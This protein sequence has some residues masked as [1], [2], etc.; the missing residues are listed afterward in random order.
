M[1]NT[2]EAIE[3]EK[4]SA[5][6][7]PASEIT[8]DLVLGIGDAIPTALAFVSPDDGFNLI[9]VN[10]AFTHLMGYAKDDLRSV[11]GW[12]EAAFPDPLFSGQWLSSWISEVEAARTEGYPAPA[13]EGRVRCK[14]GGYRDVVIQTSLLGNLIMLAFTDLTERRRVEH[15]GHDREKQFRSF[16]ENANDIIYILDLQ[17]RFTYASPNI[18]TTLGWNPV[19]LQ[20]ADFRSLVHP[21]DLA[22]YLAAFDSV[23]L[24]SQRRTG[25]EYRIRKSDGTWNWHASNVSPI[26]DDD[27][28]ISALIG[29]G[30]DIHQRKKTEEQLHI[31][32]ARY[33]LLSDHAH[34][35]IWTIAPNGAI[36]YVSP[37]VE[38]VRGF[39]QEE[40]MRQTLEQT[41]APD[42]IA[43]SVAYVSTL[44]A[45]IEAGRKPKAF[46]GQMQ[47][48]CKDGSTYWCDVMTTPI[49]AEDGSLVEL[50]GVS[51]DISQHKRYEDELK[52]AK[53]AAEALN[54]A[55]EAANE[56]LHQMA[57]TDA[58]T[59]LWN[60]RHFEERVNHERSIAVRYDQPLSVL[61]FDIDHFKLINDT[62]GHQVGDLVLVELSARARQEIRAADL[63]CRW[64]G[65]EFMI[66]MPSTA[67]HDA[68]KVAEK[69]RSVFAG[70]PVA[71]VGLVTASFGVATYGHDESMD[72]WIKRVDRALYS[73][74]EFGRNAV[75]VA[76]CV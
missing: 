24:H 9:H 10:R 26:Y 3:V 73:A 31:S 44:L 11:S 6:L 42:S 35:V 29:V 8:N 76:P 2:S 34:D 21:Q 23:T 19:E 12:A 68:V 4:A 71:G 15:A 46:R 40:S 65:E 70:A 28:K 25:I 41:L 20:G 60:R 5:L 55:L 69:L 66:L 39:T 18:Q 16:V 32:E 1:K 62:H 30:R 57:S 75:H 49:L 67:S 45:D 50:L 59:G 7:F 63:L 48:L 56:R 22:H 64:G 33:R 53:E 14:D 58:L 27:G 51:R 17:R 52:K 47:Y 74:K 13:N 54:K 72:D 38:L 36:T 37:S 61:L 43:L